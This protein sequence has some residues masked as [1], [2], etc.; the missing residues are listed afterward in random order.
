[1]LRTPI[2]EKVKW[3]SSKQM[4]TAKDYNSFCPQG[5]SLVHSLYKSTH[6]LE[7][8]LLELRKPIFNAFLTCNKPAKQKTLATAILAFQHV[9]HIIWN[10]TEDACRNKTKYSGVNFA[11]LKILPATIR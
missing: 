10:Q 1:M 9:T 3:W 4:C 2:P 8:R 5:W 6:S 7:I 11:D